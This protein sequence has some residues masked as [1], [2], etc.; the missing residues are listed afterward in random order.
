MTPQSKETEQQ[1]EEKRKAELEALDAELAQL[2]ALAQKLAADSER[3][4]QLIKQLEAS[5]RYEDK[6]AEALQKQY[7]ELVKVMD[8][9]PDAENST[10]IRCPSVCVLPMP[11]RS[12]FADIA[13]LEK[14]KSDALANIGKLAQEWEAI[15][16]RLV[17]TYRKLRDDQLH[18]VDDSTPK[19]EKLKEI[20]TEIQALTEDMQTKE[21]AYNQAME[22]F[23][24]MP[25]T[26]TR[27]HYTRRILDIVK[28]V[29]K[30][31]VDINK[32]R[33]VPTHDLLAHFYASHA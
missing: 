11:D 16:V 1:Q 33:D 31:K 29:K 17:E 24:R 32:V 23:E 27:A 25:K 21:E 18:R 26:I 8:L 22:L 3:D 28:N 30:Q 20:R 6:Q 10:H 13:K 5:L 12:P 9:L 15:R 14:M 19:A 2:Q 4:A 7:E